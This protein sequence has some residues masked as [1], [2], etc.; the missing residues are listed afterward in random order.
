MRIN[1]HYFGDLKCLSPVRSKE[2]FCGDESV[3]HLSMSKPLTQ[4]EDWERT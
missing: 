1:F 4:G 2:T 3:I